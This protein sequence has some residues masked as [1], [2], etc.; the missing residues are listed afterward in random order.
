MKSILSQTLALTAVLALSCV[1]QASAQTPAPKPKAKPAAAEAAPSAPSAPAV[2]PLQITATVPALCFLSREALLQTST[3]GQF[4]NDRM[5]QLGAVV[6]AELTGEQTTLE[7][8][9]KALEGQKAS[10][11][12]TV[13]EQRGQA[14]QQ[15]GAQFQ[16]KVQLRQREL[17]ATQ[18]KAYAHI[19][20]AA[21]PFVGQVVTQ[22]SCGA[23]IDANAVIVGN[24]TMDTTP[25]VIQLLNGSLTQFAF[26]REH[27][28]QPGSPAQ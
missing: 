19:L 3:V 2:P 18:Q 21:G 8:D 16:Q 4:V 20:Q 5:K 13:Y 17:E 24:P 25:A 1:A 15:R 22:R 11:D 27:L 10:L 26:D 23:L 9:A 12:P 6:Q 28:D 14:L 7:N